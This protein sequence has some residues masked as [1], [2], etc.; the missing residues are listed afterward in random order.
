MIALRLPT[1]IQATRLFL[2]PHPSETLNLPWQG[3][4][5]TGEGVHDNRKNKLEMSFEQ[6][7]VV[8]GTRKKECAL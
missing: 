8:T 6:L 3:G 4:G 5:G 7:L 1:I 2:D